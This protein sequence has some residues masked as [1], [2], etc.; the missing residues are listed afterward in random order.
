MELENVLGSTVRNSCHN[1]GAAFRRKAAEAD[2]TG[3]VEV[4][5]RQSR[6]RIRAVARMKRRFTFWGLV[7]SGT[8]FIVLASAWLILNHHRREYYFSAVEGP[9]TGTVPYFAIIYAQSFLV[10]PMFCL[11]G[12]AMIKLLFEVVHLAVSRFSE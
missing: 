3:S 11:F 10:W 4:M 1:A 5:V 6:S 12:L 9:S 7:L 8:M 2:A